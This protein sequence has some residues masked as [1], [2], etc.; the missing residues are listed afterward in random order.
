MKKILRSITDAV[1]TKKG[2]WITLSIWTIALV[3]VS[4]FLPSA[5]DYQVASIET[6]PEDA[7]SIIASNKINTHF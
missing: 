5:R 4:I 3:I 2:M 1:S 7:Q 6:L